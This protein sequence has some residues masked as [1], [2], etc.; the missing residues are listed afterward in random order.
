M[1]SEVGKEKELELGRIKGAPADSSESKFFNGAFYSGHSERL[2]RRRRQRTWELLMC[3]SKMG[4][5]NVVE[6][7]GKHKHERSLLFGK[8]DVLRILK[9]ATAPQI[10]RLPGTA[11]IT[12]MDF[13]S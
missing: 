4:L 3:T 1:Y 6:S 7:A 11:T 5:P 10:I 13:P 8:A 2:D 12:C 9:R